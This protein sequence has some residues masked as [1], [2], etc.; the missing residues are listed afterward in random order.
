MRETRGFSRA[1]TG[2]MLTA[3]IPLCWSATMLMQA[4]T[5]SS[6]FDENTDSTS[7]A[8]TIIAYQ[9]GWNYFFPLD[10]TTSLLNQNNTTNE[11]SLRG[12]GVSTTPCLD[13]LFLSEDS[14]PTQLSPRFYTPGLRS[15]P[16]PFDSELDSEPESELES[17]AEGGVGEGLN[18]NVP[19][20]C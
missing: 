7:M 16:E 19:T 2:D 20:P 4:S 11:P 10:T 17:G 1:Q 9:W 13:E 6:N 15:A 8:V 12:Q 5:H 3:V 18:V 14:N